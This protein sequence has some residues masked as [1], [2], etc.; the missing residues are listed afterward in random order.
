V[1]TG[2]EA[3]EALG[4][5]DIF[6]V[7]EIGEMVGFLSDLRILK[8]HLPHGGRQTVLVKNRRGN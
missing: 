6:Q 2:T 5:V 3:D 7:E 1:I 4:W 8:H